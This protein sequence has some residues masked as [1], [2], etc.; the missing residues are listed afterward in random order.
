MT[1]F[2][3]YFVLWKKNKIKYKHTTKNFSH[4]SQFSQFVGVGEQKKMMLKNAS[5]KEK[6]G[7]E[8]GSRK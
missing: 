7:N 4:F 5:E 6:N 2:F 3:L 1:K 8:K